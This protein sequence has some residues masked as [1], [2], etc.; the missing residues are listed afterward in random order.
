MET[1]HRE[2]LIG[3]KKKVRQSMYPN[4]CMYGSRRRFIISFEKQ[5]SWLGGND[6]CVYFPHFLHFRNHKNCE[7]LAQKYL[8]QLSAIF[9]IYE[10]EWEYKESAG[11]DTSDIP[12]VSLKHPRFIKAS[13]SEA[14]TVCQ[15]V[16]QSNSTFPESEYDFINWQLSHDFSWFSESEFHFVLLRLMIWAAD[17]FLVVCF[18]FI[19][20]YFF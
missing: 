20:F 19:L 10:E 9:M 4:N 6:Y 1:R 17:C 5:K 18:Y 16:R 3:R 7:W 12:Q 13:V 8:R 11:W 14:S 15:T 2:M